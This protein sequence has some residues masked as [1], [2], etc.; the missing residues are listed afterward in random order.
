VPYVLRHTGLT[1]PGKATN[2]DVFALA[3]IAGHSQHLDHSAVRS[4]PGGHYRGHL[5][6]GD[7][8]LPSS[9]DVTE[10]PRKLDAAG[11]VVG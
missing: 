3:Q 4:H 8:V 11:L 6:K 7:Q 1:R 2:G 5:C 9:Q 10:V